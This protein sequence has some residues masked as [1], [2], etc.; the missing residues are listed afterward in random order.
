MARSTPSIIAITGASSG[1]GAALAR[2]YAAHATR[3][4]L[5]ARNRKRLDS[6]AKQCRQRGADTRIAVLDV[7][8]PTAMNT[9][10]H[11]MEQSP[12]LVIAN[13]G[14]SGGQVT[15]TDTLVDDKQTRA[16][17]AVNITG[18][19][20]TVLPALT[21]MERTGHGQIALVSSL[22]GYRGLPSAPAYSA[23]K[24]AV[25]AYG[26]ALRPKLARRGIDINVIMP[27]FVESRITDKNNFRMP[28]IMTADKAAQIIARG[29][30][31]NTARIAFPWPLALMS[32]MISCTPPA[33]VDTILARLP[34]KQ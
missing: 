7:I 34:S 13:A 15:R 1:I 14:I 28:M 18:V 8:D 16:I 5:C 17:L 11:G 23:S 29:L 27:G 31:R 4:Y 33:L 26:E 25:K 6:I 21:L 32:Y 10:F 19:V 22:A 9:W 30:A 2:H 20:N 24:A 12:D 3:L